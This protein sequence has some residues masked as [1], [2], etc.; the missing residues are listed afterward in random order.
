V[1]TLTAVQNAFS[2]IGPTLAEMAIEPSQIVYLKK[3]VA[4]IFFTIGYTFQTNSTICS[5]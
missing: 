3:T 2:E 5:V 1:W 4:C